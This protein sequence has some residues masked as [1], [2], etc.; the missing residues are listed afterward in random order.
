[1]T[2]QTRRR[3]KDNLG[4]FQTNLGVPETQLDHKKFAYRWI[5]EDHLHA[6][7]EADDYDKV[8]VDAASDDLGTTI[9]RVVGK[10]EDG[11]PKRAYLCAKP[12]KLYEED[13]KAHDATVDETMTAIRGQAQGATPSNPT[14][15]NTYR[16]TAGIKIENG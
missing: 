16:P 15:E 2:R 11:S 10:H 7:T 8:K 12:R 4:G 14:P 3:R 13:R 1:M 6:R 5:N 9:S